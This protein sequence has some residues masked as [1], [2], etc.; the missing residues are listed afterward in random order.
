MRFRPPLVWPDEAPDVNDYE[1]W[2]AIDLMTHG[3]GLDG[4]QP[5][6]VER[7]A[8]R[9]LYQFGLPPGDLQGSQLRA[10]WRHPYYV[11]LF[12][13]EMGHLLHL[14]L[15]LSDI[16]GRGAQRLTKAFTYLTK[17]EGD[18]NEIEASAT[19]TLVIEQLGFP[20]TLQY[21]LSSTTTNL[22]SLDMFFRP[23][24]L[25]FQA[26]KLQRERPKTQQIARQLINILLKIK[27]VETETGAEASDP[28]VLRPA[29]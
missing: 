1:G 6:V 15:K 4:V 10:R 16:E 9:L 12:A 13:H 25:V 14:G 7:R 21:L 20:Y 17:N 8:R 22:R 27:H 5:D 28:E 24:K 23:R 3:H 11:E 26:M 19:A 2:H 29:S 18:A